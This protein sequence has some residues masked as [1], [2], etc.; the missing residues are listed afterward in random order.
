MTRIHSPNHQI[1]VTTTNKT[2]LSCFDDK[3][4]IPDNGIDTLPYGHYSL[5]QEPPKPCTT[6]TDFSSDSDDDDRA[7]LS[8]DE[9]KNLIEFKELTPH[10]GDSVS[11]ASTSSFGC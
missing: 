6:S 11:T 1:Q 3:R 5:G 8:A 2:A 7:S 9:E 4:F 10:D